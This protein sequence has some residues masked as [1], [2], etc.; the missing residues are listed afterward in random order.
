VSNIVEVKDLRK[1]FPVRERLL[2]RSKSF[3]QAVDGVS[4]EIKKGEVLGLVGE[5]GCGKTTVGR[6]ILLLIPPTSGKITFQEKRLIPTNKKQIRE[7]R[8]K[9]SLVFQD[10]SRSLHPLKTVENL[11]AE[12]L[13]YHHILNKQEI[14][15]RV[16]QL[17]AR[18]GLT[19][20]HRKKYVH[21]L[22]GGEKQRV[23]IARAISTKPQFVVADEPVAALDVSIKAGILNLIREMKRAL[24]FSCLLIS[25]DLSIIRYLCD[26]VIVMYAGKFVE[27]A[28][29]D[30]LFNNAF[31]PYTKALLSSVPVP[32]PRARALKNKLIL[33]GSP[34]SLLNPPAG[35]RLHSR[36]P[37]AEAMCSRKVPKMTE[38]EPGHFVACHF[39]DNKWPNKPFSKN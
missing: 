10:P 13:R 15:E 31:H 25:H 8:I 6:T 36:C 35:C 27:I 3:V 21:E 37:F 19:R 23:A 16:Q 14:I 24:Q 34:P 5:S 9:T 28:N 4:Y 1:Y 17:I 12:P 2:S 11:I 29:R 33:K 30:N 22:S 39:P 18:V 38:I 26:R 20:E 7:L 32:N